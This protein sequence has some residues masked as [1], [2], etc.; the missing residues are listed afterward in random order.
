MTVIRSKTHARALYRL[1][2]AALH[3]IKRLAKIAKNERDAQPDYIEGLRQLAEA[4]AKVRL[5]ERHQTAYSRFYHQT[6]QELGNDKDTAMRMVNRAKDTFAH[7]VSKEKATA[8]GFNP[9]AVLEY[10]TNRRSGSRYNRSYYAVIERYVVGEPRQDCS[11]DNDPEVYRLKASGEI[12]AA[13]QRWRSG[14]YFRDAK[15]V[16]EGDLEDWAPTVWKFKPGR[17]DLTGNWTEEEIAAEGK[18]KA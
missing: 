15:R 1:N 2:R 12:G 16:G 18:V 11:W 5:I 3:R 13:V 14:R 17:P 7:F 6:E 4:R 9:G 10:L 8:K